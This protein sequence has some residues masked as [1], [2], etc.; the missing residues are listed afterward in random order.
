MIKII[1]FLSFLLTVSSPI[2]AI[3]S[4]GSARKTEHLEQIQEKR[5]ANRIKIQTIRDTNKQ[6]IAERIN[7]QLQHFLDQAVKHFR[8]VLER[9]GKLLDKIKTRTPQADIAPAQ[10]AISTAETAVNDLGD[11]L[12]VIEFTNESS[13]RIGASNAKIK[14]RSDIKAVHDLI[15]TARKAVTDALQDAKDYE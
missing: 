4:T 12:Y 2:M 13:L 14:L 6:K 1:L 10:A 7:S 3:D 5:E 15:V 9:L 11:N 8:A